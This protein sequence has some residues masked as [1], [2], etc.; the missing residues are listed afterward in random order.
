MQLLSWDFL[1]FNPKTSIINNP[2]KH[3]KSTFKKMSLL[4]ILLVIPLAW[5]AYIGFRKGFFYEAAT[6]AG[7]IAGVFIAAIVA[8]TAGRTLAHIVDWNPM[9]IQITAFVI[10][11]LIIVIIF[12]AI[13]KLLTS[14]LKLV[15]LNIINR[16]AGLGFGIL[17]YAFILSLLFLVI[18]YINNYYTVLSDSTKKESYLFEYIEPLAPMVIP[19]KDLIIR[20]D[21]LKFEIPSKQV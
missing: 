1:I 13:G 16:I 14:L 5:G 11:F 7:V 12:A 2:A 21:S 18:N 3:N 19:Y 9:F 17:K 20:P 4:D 10:T 6:L 8:N 15:F